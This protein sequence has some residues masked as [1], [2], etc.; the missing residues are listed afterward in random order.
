MVHLITKRQNEYTSEVPEKRSKSLSRMTKSKS[1][2][3]IKQRAQS[4]ERRGKLLRKKS[5][6]ELLKDVDHSSCEC[7]GAT[8][9]NIQSSK[10]FFTKKTLKQTKH[11]N[12]GKL[13][14]AVLDGDYSK[15]R[16]CII[17]EQLEVN[18]YSPEGT[19]VLHL[20]SAAGDVD[21]V[22]LLIECGAVI[23]CKDVNGRTALEYAVLYGNFDSATTLIENGADSKCIKNGF[24]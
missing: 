8:N 18:E 14:D 11:F 20:A 7:G 15:V 16:Q 9:Q 4:L 2:S 21:I 19:T 12:S 10:D 24:H 1:T 6:K 3:D 17:E 22:E 13:F 5:S 23:D